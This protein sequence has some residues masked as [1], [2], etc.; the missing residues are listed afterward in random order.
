MADVE[1]LVEDH[2]HLPFANAP[3]R[4][5]LV[6]AAIAALTRYL[7]EHGQHLNRLEHVEKMIELKLADGIVVNGR[8]DL[9]RRTDTNEVLVVDFKS[10]ERAQAEDITSRQLQ[11][12]AV[13]YEQLTGNRADLIEIHNLDRG[14]AT[15][16]V[17]D[18]ALTAETLTIVE[19]AGRALRNNQLPRLANW[20]ESCES[21][22]LTAICR[23]EAR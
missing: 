18:G 20:C 3:V 1:R 8:I 22:D 11:V 2:L 21:C 9:I 23:S 14:G 17:V 10:Q 7:R 6:R 13:G 5:N 12:Y 19:D 4:E 15:R 16:E